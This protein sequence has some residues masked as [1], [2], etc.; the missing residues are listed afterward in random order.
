MLIIEAYLIVHGYGDAFGVR[1]FGFACWSAISAKQFVSRQTLGSGADDSFKVVSGIFNG[2]QA[3]NSE[4][5]EEPQNTRYHP[6][7]F[8]SF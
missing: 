4:Y 6:C 2:L 1:K 8:N 3:D 5:L 7:Y